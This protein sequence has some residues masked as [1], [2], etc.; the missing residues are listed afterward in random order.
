MSGLSTG[1]ITWH[2][3]VQLQ[4]ASSGK[5][6]WTSLKVTLAD[7]KINKWATRIHSSPYHL[8]DTHYFKLELA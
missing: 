2:F 5:K 3:T 8:M 6:A 1:Y 7:T 4:T